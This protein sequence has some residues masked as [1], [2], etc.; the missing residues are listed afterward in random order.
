MRAAIGVLLLAAGFSPAADAGRY[1]IHADPKSYPQG[2]PQEAL[3]S[4]LKAIDAG[5]FDYLLAQLADPAWVDDRVGR[6]HGGQFAEQVEDTRSRFDP[7][8]IKLL[9]RFLSE[10]KW[11]IA[12]DQ[13]RVTLEDVERS[14]HFVH[15][16][17][18]WYLQNRDR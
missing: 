2:I 5:K 1:G 18:R 11:N 10:G 3:A 6:L 15:K 12:G 16:G 9:R 13:G 4:V 7:A 14:I 8:T 17:D